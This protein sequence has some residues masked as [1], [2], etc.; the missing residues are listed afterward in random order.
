MK[1]HLGFTLAELLIVFGI[2]AVLVGLT[3]AIS[4]TSINNS[5]FDRVTDTVRGELF[6]AQA[7][8]IAGTHDSAWGVAFG[9]NSLTRYKGNSFATRD[10]TFDLVTDFGNQVIISGADEVAF[11]RPY[12]IPVTSVELSIYDGMRHATATINYIGTIEIN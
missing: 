8:T 10:Q 11:T 9:T 4:N 7:D 12:G 1:K 6:A 3:A 2:V 5:E